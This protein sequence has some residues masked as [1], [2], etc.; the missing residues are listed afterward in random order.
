M[1]ERTLQKILTKEYGI[2]SPSLEFLREGGSHTYVVN[3]KNKYLLKVIGHAFSN[4]ASK[5]ISIMRYLKKMDSRCLILYSQRTE[6]QD[7]HRE[8]SVKF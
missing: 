3:G 4:T 8:L 5:S 1:D 6:K 7:G 2:D